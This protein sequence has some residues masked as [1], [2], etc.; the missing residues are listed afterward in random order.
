MKRFAIYIILF[1][2]ILSGCA[3]GE[4]A[5]V[6]PLPDAVDSIAVQKTCVD[7]ENNYTYMEKLI[8]ETEAIESFCKQLDKIRF[9]ETEPLEFSSVD[10]LI[11]FQ[12]PKKR[13]LLLSGDE[14][15]YDGRAYKS[16]KGTL[17]ET[18]AEIYNSLSLEE[19]LTDSKLF[20]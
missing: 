7:E 1:V 19:K 20:S 2:M 6:T 10:Y 14:I 13:K 3:S 11:V 15:I 4:Y 16:V 5:D 8:E 12:G 17:K 9:V 18:M